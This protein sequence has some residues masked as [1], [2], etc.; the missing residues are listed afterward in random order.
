MFSSGSGDCS[1][2]GVSHG[3][4]VECGSSIFCNLPRLPKH[5]NSPLPHYTAVA[6]PEIR[7]LSD[8]T[9]PD[10]CIDNDDDDDDDQCK[11]QTSFRLPALDQQALVQY[12]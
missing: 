2:R 6:L 7:L 5:R 3:W 1:P 12:R 11:L 10:T 8:S 9:T 4:G